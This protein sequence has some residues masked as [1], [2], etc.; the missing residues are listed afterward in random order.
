MKYYIRFSYILSVYMGLAERLK[1]IES[2]QQPIVAS[3][4]PLPQ[5]YDAQPHLLDQ[6]IYPTQQPIYPTNVPQQPIYPTNVPQQPSYPTNVPQQPIYPTSVPQQPSCPTNVPQQPS[7]STS[8]PQQPIPVKKEGFLTSL[9]SKFTQKNIVQQT[10]PGPYYNAIKQRVDSVIQDKNLHY[11]YPVN[12]PQY[13]ALLIRLSHIDFP[14][15]A[16]KRKI[17]VE[18]AFDLAALG[19]TDVILFIDD[20]GSMNFDEQWNTSTE[21]TDDL[22]LILSRIVDI[23]SMFDDDGL[24]LRFFNSNKEFDNIT[25]EQDAMNALAKVHYNGGTP[26][27]RSLVTKILEPFV[28]AKARNNKL[29]KPLMI[30]II[31][32]GVP[33]NKPEVKNN[34]RKCKDWLSQTSYGKSAVN[35]MFAQVGNSQSAAQYLKNE[36]DNDPDIGEDVDTTGNF[37]MEYEKYI[38]KGVDLTPD[39]WLLQMTLGSIVRAYDE[40]ND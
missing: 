8:V 26:I 1:A 17:P 5:Q 27:G 10:A 2:T 22:K 35:I 28:Y 7:Y 39:L 34:I 16:A 14:A 19:V 21:K 13:N 31:T 11:F 36:L 40:G 23:A 30:Y 15:I 33:D 4:P 9:T 25:N 29:T 24:C 20:S 38:T 32:D 3:A 12:S 37:E 18:L 6:P